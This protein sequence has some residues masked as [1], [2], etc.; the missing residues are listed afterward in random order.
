MRKRKYCFWTALFFLVLFSLGGCTKEES[1][2]TKVFYVSSDGTYIEGVPYRTKEEDKKDIVVELLQQLR[3]DPGNVEL[4]QTIPDSVDYTVEVDN[5]HIQLDFSGEYYNLSTSE[6]LLIRAA[7]VKTLLQHK[8]FYYI[9]FRVEGEPLVDK[10]GN[11]VGSMGLDSFVENPGQQI[12]SSIQTTLTLYFSN[13]DGTALVP[14]ERK[15]TYSA[16]TSMEKLIMQQLIE[17]A[18]ESGHLSTIP[19]ATKIFN[20]AVSDHVCFVN[21]DD[22]F[23][24]QNVEISESIVLYS[25][26]NSLTQLQDVNQVLI[27][28][29]GD[30]TGN[31]RFNKKLSVLYERDLSYLEGATQDTQEESEEA[32]YD[33]DMPI[34]APSV[35]ND[36]GDE[37]I[38]NGTEEPEQ[39]YNQM[40]EGD[41]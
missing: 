21:L 17:G 33:M 13:S 12:N 9:V 18:K 36:G 39:F 38:E 37:V 26:V 10:D 8:N 19:P 34:P 31:V 30:N 28:V 35:P 5:Y 15:V 22:A 41:R 20:I 6:E 23:R 3:V 2:E 11:E 1:N 29:N 16:S 24:N 32:S 4:K 7:I 27:S 25:I 40:M 14:E